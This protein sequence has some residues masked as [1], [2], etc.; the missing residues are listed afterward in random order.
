MDINKELEIV[1]L[2]KIKFGN[3]L[4]YAM[5][6]GYAFYHSELGYLS[7]KSSNQKYKYGV[8][9]PYIPTGGIKAL[10]EIIELGGFSNF[11]D[12]EWIHPIHETKLKEI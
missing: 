10:E 2:N 11:D 3:S 12:I 1:K 4:A 7:L 8:K 9:I 5:P 6:K